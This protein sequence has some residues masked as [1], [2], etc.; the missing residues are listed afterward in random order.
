MIIRPERPDDYSAILQ[1]TYKAFLTS[2]YPGRRRMDEHYLIHLLKGSAYVIPELCFVAEQDGEIVG[3]ILYTTSEIL[4]PDGTTTDTITFGPLS[5]LPERHRQGIGSALVRYSMEKAR[6]MGFGA[7]LITGVPDYYPKLGFKRARDYGLTLSDGT[8]DDSFM[9]YELQPGYLAG[10]GTLRFLPPEFEQAENDDAGLDAFHKQFMAE[11]YPSQL[12][13][14]PLFDGDIALMERWLYAPHV[15][16]WYKH[17]DHWLNEL[18]ERRG[19]FSFL[20]HFITEFEGV[21]IGFCQYYDCFYAQQHEVWNDQWRVG[22]GQGEI[23]S[24][25]YLIGESDYLR[26]GFGKEMIAKMLDML[27]KAG[28]RTVIVEPERDNTASNRALEANG[29]IWNGADYHLELGDVSIN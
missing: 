20:T 27:R 6:E 28:A 29:F 26:R 24:I 17:P 7:V 8:A 25:D 13:L 1:L 2:D 5:V 12:T 3:H 15:A 19:E 21:P 14:R 18:N 23:F 16:E 10:G 11:N 22:D 9:A 4:R